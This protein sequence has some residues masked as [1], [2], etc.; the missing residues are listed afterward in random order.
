MFYFQIYND[1]ISLVLHPDWQQQGVQL[2]PLQPRAGR[3]GEDGGAE[4]ETQSPAADQ[5]HH[6]DA[7]CQEG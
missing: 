2:G 7:E 6:P 1:C 3:G 4:A 5:D